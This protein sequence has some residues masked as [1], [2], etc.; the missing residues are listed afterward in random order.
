MFDEYLFAGSMLRIGKKKKIVK[1]YYYRLT[2]EGMLMYY[3]KVYIFIYFK[4]SDT[5]PKGFI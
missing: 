4:E 2:N 1:G 3:K 5:L